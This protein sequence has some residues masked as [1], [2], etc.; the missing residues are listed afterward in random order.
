MPEQ[1]A[2]R[3][4]KKPYLLWYDRARWVRRARQQLRAKPLCRMCAKEGQVVAAAVADHIVPHKGNEQ[5]FWFGA[6]QSLCWSCHSRKTGQIEVR[7]YSND[8]GVD[9]WPKDGKHPANSRAGG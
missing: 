7:G 5:M 1:G 8:V 2:T 3:R 9:G 4:E 6:L